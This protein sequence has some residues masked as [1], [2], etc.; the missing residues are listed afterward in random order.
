MRATPG[1]NTAVALFVGAAL[2]AGV[3]FGRAALDGE[4]RRDGTLVGIL[5]P[6]YVGRDR[7]APDFDL[8]DRNG[9]HYRLS[10]FRGKTVVLHFWS[11]DCPPCIAELNESIPEFEE[12]IRGRDD[13]VFLM[14]TVDRDW[15]RIAPLVP[16]NLRA[17]VL[18]DP[19]RA[20]VERRFGT[21]LFPETWVIDRGGVIRARFDRTLDWR[22]SAFVQYITHLR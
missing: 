11:S 10:S 21:R 22:S 12:I 6:D 13:V 20:V 4:A 8:Q 15:A 19:T 1:K 14:V 5:A 17:P 18:F 2:V 16:A 9:R 7:L 3:A